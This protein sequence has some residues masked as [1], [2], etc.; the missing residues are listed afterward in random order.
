MVP[1]S[2]VSIRLIVKKYARLAG[3]EK[4]ISPHSLRHT[5]ITLSLDGGATIRQVQYLAGHSDPKTTM[6]YDRH[7]NNLDDHATDYINLKA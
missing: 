3:I 1:L 7:R 2:S 4:Q 6:R 5:A